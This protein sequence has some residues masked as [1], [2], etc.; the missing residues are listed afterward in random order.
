MIEYGTLID[1]NI[2]K[3]DDIYTYF[4]DYFNNPTMVKIKNIM[5]S[6]MYMCKTY[7]LLNKDCRYIIV[8]VNTDEYQN[9]T[10][11]P[12]KNMKWNILQ[13]RTLSDN[14]NLPMHS[15]TP[16]KKGPLTSVITRVKHDTKHSEYECSKIPIKIVLIHTK[17]DINE[18]R[19]KG[20]IN[21]ALE[22][23]STIVSLA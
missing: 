15:Y 4:D 14:H 18:F 13:T 11:I 8:F 16:S 1:E 9:G 22:T 10:R 21:S 5:D 20:Y 17:D 23:Y 3:Y 6:S 7:C 2:N 19:P 12:L